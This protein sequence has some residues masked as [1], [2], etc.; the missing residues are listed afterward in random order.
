LH[1]PGS[2]RVVLHPA[3]GPA[4]EKADEDEVGETVDL[5]L[6]ALT[7]PVENVEPY[8][9]YASSDKVGQQ[10]LLPGAGQYA[11]GL[12]GARGSGHQL[13]R[14]TNVVEETKAWWLKFR[15]EAPPDGT[16]LEGVC[17]GI[18]RACMGVS[19]T[20]PV[21]HASLIG[22]TPPVPSTIEAAGPRGSQARHSH[23]H[24]MRSWIHRIRSQTSPCGQRTL[25]SLPK[26]TTT[27]PRCVSGHRARR[28]QTCSRSARGGRKRLSGQ[29]RGFF[30][31]GCCQR[32]DRPCDSLDATGACGSGHR[33]TPT[34]FARDFLCRQRLLTQIHRN[35][36][37]LRERKPLTD[38]AGGQRL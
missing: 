27:H 25:C 35:P 3:Y 17:A 26:L 21:S 38:S 4:W 10:C 24:T 7:T 16:P 23:I 29:R 37:C 22:Y 18:A 36:C 14:V 12:Q 5:A 19:N 15:F 6:V 11:D 9:L 28:Q 2:A 13:R 8:A 34:L 1:P 33:R 31:P 30:T 32:R 20:I